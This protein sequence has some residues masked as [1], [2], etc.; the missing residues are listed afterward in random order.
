M[1]SICL[2]WLRQNLRTHDNEALT[3]AIEGFDLVLPVYCFEPRLFTKTPLIGAPKMGCFRT[4]FL[5]ESLQDLR[6][7]L[8]KIN[9]NLY[10][11]KDS[12]IETFE[13]LIAKLPQIRGIYGQ[14][15]FASEE[16][17]EEKLLENLARKHNLEFKLFDTNSLFEPEKLPF[18]I[19]NLSDVFTN[20]RNLVEKKSKVREAFFIEQEKAKAPDLKNWGNIPTL[21]DFFASKAIQRQSPKAAIQH[22][23]G[24][25]KALERLQ[26]YLW[27]SDLIKS[28]KQTRNGLLGAD[29]SSKFSAWLASGCISPV[30]IYQ[31]IQKYEENRGENESTYWLF[32]ELLWREYFGLSAKKFGN[33]IFQ[34]NGIANKETNG[35]CDLELFDKW[36]LGQTD[37]DFVNA[38][39]RELIETGFMSNRG[40]QNVASYLVH[41]LGLDW[42]MGAEWFE[43]QLIDYDVYSNWGNWCYVAGVGH[44]PRSRKFNIQKQAKDYD[45]KSE[46]VEYWLRIDG[47]RNPSQK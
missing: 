2:L 28:Y 39:M 26:Y 41:D 38:N 25:S 18:E 4:R 40:R 36:R 12:S 43:S 24:E 33:K 6:E 15:E 35:K 9:L 1:Q 44:D 31:E 17:A 7:N 42:R 16:I 3:K 46:Y 30:Q 14:K 22:F 8:K 20:F 23:G 29:Y 34:K 37:E 5:L 13:R 10:I 47:L 32:F 27:E 19:E 45:P 11:S 21:E